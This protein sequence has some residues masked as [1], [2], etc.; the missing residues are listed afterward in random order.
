[1]ALGTHSE[2]PEEGEDATFAVNLSDVTS[3]AEVEVTFAVDAA[4]TAA[5][6]T[7]Y[8][9]P[10]SW[11]LTI[12]AGDSSG[13]ITIETLT[14]Q[15]LDPDET[16]VVKL[17]SAVTDTRTVTVE[18]TATK[19]ATIKDTG[20]AKVS[21]GPVLVED[22]DQ[23]PE[24]E[25]DDKSS[26]EEGETASFVVTLD[27]AVSGTVSVTYTTADG[28][29]ESGTGKDYT[30]A[31]GTLQFTTGQTSKTIEVTTLEDT[32][33]EAAETYTLTLTGVSGV[34]GVSLGTDSAAT[35]TMRMTTR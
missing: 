22:D 4:S 33:N 21:V 10:T 18:A 31:S 15:V 2:E 11:K 28:T 12:A 7:D 14:D 34:D 13:T 27:G 32:L 19:T 8:T 23:T 6:G 1:M 5:S 35:G 17:V 29:A 30:T 16:L 9:A 24:D 25:S 26:V 3:T 20:M